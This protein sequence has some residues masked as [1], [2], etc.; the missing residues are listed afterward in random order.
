MFLAEINVNLALIFQALGTRQ[1]EEEEEEVLMTGSERN[2]LSEAVGQWQEEV[3]S[4]GAAAPEGLLVLGGLLG[5]LS[6]LVVA[7]IA[8]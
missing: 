8:M 2:G 6:L 3:G 4:W 5:A 7:M 1:P